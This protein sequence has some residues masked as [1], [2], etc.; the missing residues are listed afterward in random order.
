MSEFERKPPLESVGGYTPFTDH[1]TPGDPLAYVGVRAR[2]AIYDDLLSSPR[3]ID[4]NPAPVIDFIEGIASNTYEFS[5]KL[6]G[7]L[8]YAVIREIAENFIHAQF[9]ECT[10]SILDKGNTIRFS[11]QG[12]GIEKKHLVQQPGI[13]S[14]TAEMKR[15]IKGVGSGFPIVKEYLDYRHGY[16]AIDDNAKEGA[17]I[18]ISIQSEP[19]QN[20]TVVIDSRGAQEKTQKIKLDDRSLSTLYLLYE[21]GE[22][23]PSDL[24]EPLGISAATAHRILVSLDERGFVESTP[25]RKRILS[26]AGLA[27]LEANKQQ[28]TRG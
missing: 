12:P 3:V 24:T 28:G 1:N 20:T 26:S 5:Q 27:V 16:L 18:T 25:N 9:K 14:A 8:P 13:S 23:G 21:K 11:D 19:T 15:F 7:G 17:V 10:I 22:L 2:I 6:G 4:I